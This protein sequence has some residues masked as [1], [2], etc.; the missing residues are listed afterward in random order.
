MI[1]LGKY[2]QEEYREKRAFLK[3]ARHFVAKLAELLG[4]PRSATAAITNPTD[5]EMDLES[6]VFRDD[7][8][9]TQRKDESSVLL[10][11]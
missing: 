1:P 4:E 11:D 8:E 7:L 9:M 6:D 2:M 3:R 5:I 10:E